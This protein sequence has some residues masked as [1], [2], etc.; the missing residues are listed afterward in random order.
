MKARLDEFFCRYAD[1]A[2]DGTHEAVL[3][4]GQI[5]LAGPAS[6][7]R[8]SFFERAEYVGADGSPRGEGYRPAK[9]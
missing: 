7:G 8:T 5:D 3:G 6:Q 1:P 9:L 4:T 2:R